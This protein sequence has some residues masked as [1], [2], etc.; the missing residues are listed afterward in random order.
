MHSFFPPFAI[1]VGK[2]PHPC[3][4]QFARS[5]GWGRGAAAAKFA[6][7]TVDRCVAHCPRKGGALYIGVIPLAQGVQFR[8]FST[9]TA[10][11]ATYTHLFLLSFFFFCCCT[12]QVIAG[13]GCFFLMIHFLTH[14]DHYF[15]CKKTQKHNPSAIAFLDHSVKATG[16]FPRHLHTPTHTHTLTH[17][18]RALRF[19]LSHSSKAH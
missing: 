14:E 13:I 17:T 3:R 7:T 8:T 2:L 4:T 5:A 18:L 12:T 19:F 11:R 16:N 15:P 1:G 10:H 9:A 6:H